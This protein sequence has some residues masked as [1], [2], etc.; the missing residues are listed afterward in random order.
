M[1]ENH[2][3]SSAPPPE[4][5]TPADLVYCGVGL[6]KASDYSPAGVVIAPY[7]ADAPSA[8]AEI[9]SGEILKRALINGQWQPVTNDEEFLSLRGHRGTPL[10]LE[11]QNQSGQ[12]RE[13]TLL[14]DF[15][16]SPSIDPTHGNIDSK[17][18]GMIISEATEGQGHGLPNTIANLTAPS[19]QQRS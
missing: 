5:T 19:A 2:N 8:A 10:T 11:I 4:G 9:K 18:C 14:R 12:T 3:F 15:V 1:S 13:V 6:M 16:H 7:S 17:S